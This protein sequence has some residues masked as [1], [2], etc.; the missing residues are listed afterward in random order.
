MEEKSWKMMSP[1]EA[2][3]KA[4]MTMTI[5]VRRTRILILA[6]IKMIFDAS[7]GVS[8]AKLWWVLATHIYQVTVNP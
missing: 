7:G 2:T 8:E 4:R 6:K 1:M 3:P 5:R